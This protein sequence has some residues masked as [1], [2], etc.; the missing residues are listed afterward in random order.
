MRWT[1]TEAN[2]GPAPAA[3]CAPRR[4]APRQPSPPCSTRTRAQVCCTESRPAWLLVSLGA[5]R[6]LAA[7]ALVYDQDLSYTLSLGNA[8]NGPFV[9]VAQQAC[10]ACVMNKYVLPDSSSSDLP[11]GGLQSMLPRTRTVHQL[12]SSS[13]SAAFVRLVVSWSSGG[14]VGGCDDLCDWASNVYEL[15]AFSPG[16]LVSSQPALGA[17]APPPSLVPELPAGSCSD[18]SPLSSM[19][20]GDAVRLP[21]GSVVLTP[22]EPLRFGAAEYTHVIRPA[23]DCA[24]EAYPTVRLARITAYVWLG[25]SASMPGEGLVISLVD[26]RRQTPG[27]TVFKRGCGT[28]PALPEAAV[29]IVLDT[30]DSD[31]SCDEPGTGARFVVSLEGGEKPP[32]VLCSTLDM[33]TTSFRKGEWI[34]IQIDFQENTNWVGGG[35]RPLGSMARACQR[36]GN[37]QSVC[38]D[39]LIPATHSRREHLTGGFLHRCVG[40]HGHL[41]WRSPRRFWSAH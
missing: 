12:A 31:P 11:A 30:G 26:A 4:D 1:A 21:D 7:L 41:W 36:N 27:K 34:S 16:D 9:Q 35:H 24:C 38:A 13:A 18:D 23:I 29:S 39:E 15:Q 2:F 37:A 33:S 17:A 14:G 10:K 20:T 6:P 8:S 22:P 40:A 28:R 5:V 25:G 3:R 19:L 32:L